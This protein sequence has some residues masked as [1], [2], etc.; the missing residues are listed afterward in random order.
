MNARRKIPAQL[1]LLGCLATTV[2]FGTGCGSLAH[3]SEGGASTPAYY[4][5][6]PVLV[7][8]VAQ[9]QMQDI[10]RL[11]QQYDMMRRR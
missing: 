7:D 2:A 4:G 5:Q 1:I 3:L 11:R 6:P 8:T 10:M 9:K